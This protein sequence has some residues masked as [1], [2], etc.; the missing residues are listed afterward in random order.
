MLLLLSGNEY[1]RL[2]SF[3]G[4]PGDGPY[5]VSEPLFLFLSN[6]IY[7]AEIGLGLLL[8]WR[9]T[10]QLGVVAALIFM[11]ATETTAREFMFGTLFVC[12]ILLFARADVLNRLVKP[13]TAFLAIL[14]LVRLGWLPEVLFY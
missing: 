5:T 13:I 10:R 3:D 8:L 1:T 6:S 7:V 4:R 12:T 2:T 14:L 11:V 9:P